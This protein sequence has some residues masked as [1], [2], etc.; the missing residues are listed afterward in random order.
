MKFK[1]GDR[2]ILVTSNGMPNNRYNPYGEVG[3]VSGI[4][5]S[6]IFSLMV[7]WTN[8]ACNVYMEDDLRLETKLHKILAGS[9]SG[10]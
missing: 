10:V 5:S 4:E 8:G 3:I 6:N 1:V 2:V 7:N 9:S